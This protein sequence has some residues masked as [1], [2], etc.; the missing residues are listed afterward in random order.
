MPDAPWTIGGNTRTIFVAPTGDDA[1]LTAAHQ[2]RRLGVVQRRSYYDG[3]EYAALNQK[4]WQDLASDITEGYLPEHHRRHH[5]ADQVGDGIDFLADQ[6]SGGMILRSN[7][8]EEALRETV[9]AWIEALFKRSE[10]ENR[11]QE[12][13]KEILIAGDL[14]GYIVAD[15]DADPE[16]GEP[17]ARIEFWEAES[18][19]IDYAPDDWSRMTEVRLE[20]VEE[21]TF[22]DEIKL[23]VVVRRFNLLPWLQPD[24]EF[25]IELTERRYELDT[26]L[27]AGGTFEETEPTETIRHSLPFFPFVHLHSEFL[28]MRS[29]WGK[30]SITELLMQTMDRYNA[31]AQLEFLAARYNATAKLAVIGDW[32]KINLEN[33]VIATDIGDVLALP[34][35][36]ELEALFL[37][38]DVALL[39]QH[40]ETLIDSLFRELGLQ[41][42]DGTK[43]KSFGAVS[44][45]A[46]EILNRQTDGT[47]RRI[48]NN[49]AT[50]Y[51]ELLAMA[52][53]VDTFTRSRII[54]DEIPQETIDMAFE[55]DIA[56]ELTFV[57]WAVEERED[58]PDIF[59]DGETFEDKWP[60]TSIVADFGS[61]Y[62]V[63]EVAVRDDFNSGLISRA[64][65]LRRKRYTEEE[66][67][68]IEAEIVAEEAAGGLSGALSQGT[69]FDTER[70]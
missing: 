59:P 67:K 32:A 54:V 33:E 35:G 49:L 37:Q 13:V 44:G 28:E 34:G 15:P 24:G 63:D 1:T 62:I 18:M 7:A 60:D 56:A 39:E 5:Y 40:K 16:L 10:L 31:T 27:A 57:E 25:R 3:Q 26:M 41:R 2:I 52:F 64:E 23:I 4:T 68:Q 12:T 30:P 45:Y 61:A 69:R 42:L 58:G 53:L 17:A 66:I 70:G 8:E 55:M 29:M 19:E 46:L 50:G 48:V 6:V 11:E 21:I 51:R 14:L 20:T 43:I 38:T 65:A 9:T 22:E 36:Q 47:F